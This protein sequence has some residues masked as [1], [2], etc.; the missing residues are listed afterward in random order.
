[1]NQRNLSTISTLLCLLAVLVA[2]ALPAC[3]KDDPAAPPK[4]P[5]S[6]PCFFSDSDKPDET[7][8]SMTFE[9]DGI[10]TPAAG[11]VAEWIR[12]S[13]YLAFFGVAM[14]I[15]E[16]AFSRDGTTCV[17]EV[18]DLAFKPVL[19][20]PTYRLTPDSRHIF[21]DYVSND[22][23][24]VSGNLWLEA[25][26][27]DGD[28][29]VVRRAILSFHV[30]VA[31]E[32]CAT[33]T[34]KPDSSF[35]RIGISTSE[36]GDPSGPP[37]R[38]TRWD[39]NISLIVLGPD[40]SGTLETGMNIVVL[41]PAR[42]DTN[43]CVLTVAQAQLTVIDSSTNPI[44]VWFYDFPTEAGNNTAENDLLKVDYLTDDII[45]A[46]GKIP[47]QRQ[48]AF[49]WHEK[50]WVTV[51]LDAFEPGYVPPRVAD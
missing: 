44:T 3:K 15:Q 41:E 9:A 42:P 21:A 14:T 6:I 20:G 29:V 16:P 18:T 17:L 48:D 49:G 22:A 51:I 35:Y 37:G 32:T 40:T 50:V 19:D 10:S 43:G 1:M 11:T 47:M 33:V 26:Y 13:G 34:N 27:S 46:S 39:R 45:S 12:G 31:N 4:K 2:A 28:S 25:E 8:W 23:I 36:T 5:T 24:D 7:R 30:Q 38:T